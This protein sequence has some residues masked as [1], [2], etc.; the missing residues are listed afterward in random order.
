MSRRSAAERYGSSEAAFL[1]SILN[2]GTIDESV[3]VVAYN[4]LYV[5]EYEPT[6][7]EFVAL[8][9]ARL[10][11]RGVPSHDFDWSWGR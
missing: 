9:G 8:I 2:S 3:Q 4:L 5:A 1:T 7:D 11:R 6:D 10:S